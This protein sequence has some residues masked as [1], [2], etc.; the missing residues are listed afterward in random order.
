MNIIV[1]VYGH[2]QDVFKKKEFAVELPDEKSTLDTLITQIGKLYG[3]DTEREL[4]PRES[5]KFPLMVIVGNKDYRFL[6]GMKTSLHEGTIVYFM[7]PAVGGVKPS[8]HFET[9][10]KHPLL[11]NLWVIRKF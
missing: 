2:L 3:K 7:P 8:S 9:F 6:K 1:K 10:A 11:L 5:A 4:R